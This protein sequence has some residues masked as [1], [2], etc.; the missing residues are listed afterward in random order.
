[1]FKDLIIKET[2]KLN[3]IASTKEIDKLDSYCQIIHQV[4]FTNGFTNISEPTEIVKRHIGESIFLLNSVNQYIDLS[5][6]N[7]IDIGSGIGIPGLVIHLLRKN[8]HFDLLESNQKRSH[9][10]S[11][12]LRDLKI[13]NANV[14]NQ[15]AENIG[16]EEKYRESYDWA[17]AK[18][19]APLNILLEYAI[20][21]LKT[22]GL[23]F[24]PKGSESK[25]EANAIQNASREL[26]CELLE[27]IKIPSENKQIDQVIVVVKKIGDTPKKYPRRPGMPSKR[28]L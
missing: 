17:T 26:N 9:F 4:G 23:F 8:F 18:A 12:I 3:V 22:N 2:E 16:Q 5:H 15:R 28:P 20:P 13:N 14:I 1:M 11:K 24:A 7:V 25:K 27:L 21:L 19:V 6:P 10:L